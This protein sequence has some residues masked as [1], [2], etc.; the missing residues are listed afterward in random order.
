MALG[1]AAMTTLAG[2][3]PVAE[4]YEQLVAELNSMANEARTAK[5]Q[6]EILNVFSAIEEKL[7]AFRKEYAGTTE[8]TEASFH[9]GTLNS[10]A[11]GLTQDVAYYTLAVRY[12][13]EYVTG[14]T[15][16]TDRRNLATAHYYLAES[17][18]ATNMFDD[19]RAEYELII[20]EFG[21]E[22]RQLTEF[23]RTNLQ[24]LELQRKLAVG[25]EPIAFNVK[26]TTGETLS[27]ERYKGKVLLLDFW[28]TWC[29]PCTA[30]MPHVKQV[31]AKY[32]K[33]GFEIVG[34]SLD[35]SR[36][37]LDQYVEKNGITWPQYFDGKFWQNDIATRYGVRSIPTTYLIDRK[38]KIRY[39]SLRG[40]QLEDAVNQLI[41]EKI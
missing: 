13:A 23:A 9:L 8:A 5:S 20:S 17:Y 27:P 15:E 12:L 2:D 34:I 37:S 29:R 31:Y 25:S 36:S 24:D 30:E 28:A 3:K 7:H 33:A 35:R 6:Q 22:N 41:A 21:D 38:G 39:K 1:I 40:K 19:A 4:V 14:A 26:S 11:G 32:K 10:S 16:S 18:K